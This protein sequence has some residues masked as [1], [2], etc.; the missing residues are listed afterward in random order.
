M[1]G[2]EPSAENDEASAATRDDA[3]HAR[4]LESQRRDDAAERRDAAAD[5]RDLF[6]G[7]IRADFD[8]RL[9]ELGRDLLERVTRKEGLTID[10][11]EWP[12][13]SPAALVRLR[14]YLAE[15]QRLAASDRAA[16]VMLLSEIRNEFRLQQRDR[17]EAAYER[18]AAAGDR[19][20]AA[21]DRRACRRDRDHS[22][23]DRSQAALER[24]LVRPADLEHDE[25]PALAL[26]E[27][28]SLART[29]IE[30]AR[31]KILDTREWL[32]RTRGPRET[33]PPPTTDDGAAPNR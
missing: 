7:E 8:I 16:V 29:K 18:L 10:P 9:G 11:G 5:A 26:Q 22:L 27:Q 6:S 21:D 30:E 23:Q 1:V 25:D 2:F 20:S 31:Q 4:D 17:Q 32:A 19:D 14:A 28:T 13:I 12:D 3:A 33:P 15:Q 24:E